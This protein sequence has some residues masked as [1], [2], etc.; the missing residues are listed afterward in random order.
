MKGNGQQPAEKASVTRIQRGLEERAGWWGALLN[1]P[2]LWAAVAVIGCTWLMLPRIG[3]GPPDWQPGDVASFDLVIPED[4]TLP[5]EAATETARQ[6]ARASVIPVYD[7]EPRLRIELEDEIHILFAGCRDRM[8]A[9][10]DNATDLA[11]ITDL[12][13]TES[14]MNVFG[15]TRGGSGRGCQQSISGPDRG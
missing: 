3:T 6:E 8:G 12:R 13:A 2:L 1:L 5:D 7:L 4:A 11:A 14:L 9:T 15:K 10:D